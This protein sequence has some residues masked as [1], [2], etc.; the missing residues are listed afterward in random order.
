M[1]FFSLL[2]GLTGAL[3]GSQ[4]SDVTFM[5]FGPGHGTQVEYLGPD[6]MSYLWYPGNRVVVP[7]P[8]KIRS[9]QMCFRYPSRSY[10]P[11]TGERGGRWE[12]NPL[13]V[14]AR[15]IVEQTRSDIFGLAKRK[16][17]PFVLSPQRTTL[18]NLARRRVPLTG[19]RKSGAAVPP[20][21]LDINKLTTSCAYAL[22]HQNADRLAMTVAGGIYFWGGMRSDTGQPNGCVAV[23]YERA[24]ALFRRTGDTKLFNDIVK[25]LNQK[26]VKGEAR[27]VAAIGRIDL[28]PPR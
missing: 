5:H 7:A 19:G 20:G 23:D 6:G 17:V 12:C 28:T 18:S 3:A 24:F 14:Y 22:A 27:A 15:T 16:T 4:Y 25:I 13:S 10:N 11:V 9:S 21:A 26:A 2:T 1:R 8:W